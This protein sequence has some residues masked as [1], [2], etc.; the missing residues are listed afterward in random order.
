MEFH[1]RRNTA[2]YENKWSIRLTKNAGNWTW[3]NGRALT[4]C[5]WALGETR[6][7]HDAAFMYKQSSNGE[8]GVFGGV[9]GTIREH[10]HAYICEISKGKLF[11][12]LL[13]LLFCFV[14][15]D[16]FLFLILYLS[17]PKGNRSA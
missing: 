3:V 9:N 14:C 10:P 5:K 12:L 4:Y 8:R 16:C 6:G 15:Y 17:K 1:Q 2:H 13:L 7:V 11:F